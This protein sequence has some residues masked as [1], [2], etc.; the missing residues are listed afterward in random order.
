MTIRMASSAICAL[1]L[2]SMAPA[3]QAQLAP[4]ATVEAFVD[5]VFNQHKVAE[6]FDRYVG[7][8]YI[9]HNPNVPDGRD[10]A[11]KGLTWLVTNS[12]QLRVAVKRVI[13]QGDLVA[14]HHHMTRTPDD[15][16]RA[17]V[18]IFRLE[19]GKIVEHWDVV[20]DVPA[21]A[22]DTNTMF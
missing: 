12:P 15:R 21:E 16:G 14:V 1:A 8:T 2:L 3:A 19:K 4:A 7:P 20:E 22:K 9:Q 17:V 10:G 18:D 6:A 11:V 13:A 5:T